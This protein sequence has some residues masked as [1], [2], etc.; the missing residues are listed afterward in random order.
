MADSRI[1]E[2]PALGATPSG[3]AQLPVAQGGTTLS[4]T[5]TQLHA[6]GLQLGT[7]STQASPGTHLHAGVYAGTALAGTAAAGLMPPRSGVET[8]FLNGLG[9]FSTPT[10]GSGGVMPNLLINGDMR[11]SQRGATFTSTSAPANSDDTY[12]LDR[13][14]LL[15]DGNDIVDVSQSTTVPTGYSNSIKL[16]VETA[17][18]QFGIVTILENKDSI[19]LI[20]GV[21]S[22]TFQARMAAADDNTHSIKA[23]VLSWSSTADAV[24]SDVVGTWA[25]SITPAANW[26]AENAPASNTLTTSWQEFKIENIAIDTASA[27]NVAV[28][29]YCDQTDGA[30]DDAIYITGVK[31][32]KGATATAFVAR[33]IAEEL[34]LCMRYYEDMNAAAS[35]YTYFLPGVIQTASNIGMTVWKYTIPK[36]TTPVI[37]FSGQTDFQVDY[38][39]ATADSTAMTADMTGAQST[40]LYAT[41]TG[42]PASNPA[43]MLRANNKTTAFI[44]ATAEL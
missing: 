1:T 8:E 32:E 28:L 39:A 36:R 22:L 19:P 35:A 25:A 15:S 34:N 21:A 37:S 27:A 38:V 13:W 3:T 17:N 18:K 11:I 43:F 24:T 2:L 5:V 7:A 9:A 6:A 10:G 33:P 31:L 16:E 42:T 23:A 44:A 29:F 4:I 20:G 40:R 14:N 12:L 41:I 26:T 30:V